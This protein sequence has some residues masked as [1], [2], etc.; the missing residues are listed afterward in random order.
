VSKEIAVLATVAAGGAVAAQAPAN[1]VLS[2]YV[3]TFGAA[4]VNFLVGTTCVL[5][6]TFAFAG[7][8]GGD[9]GAESPAWYYWVLG[10]IG[11]L[12]IVATTLITVR[13]LGAGGVTAATIAGQLALSVVLDR[14][15]V[16]GL[17]ERAITWEKLLGIALLAL[18][19]L[20]IVRE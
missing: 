10:G 7:G 14:L 18:G 9:Q 19:T 4:S 16:L 1:N 15:G 17:E 11:G 5:I 13:E 3:G 6:V 8:F 2:K 20:L 12:A